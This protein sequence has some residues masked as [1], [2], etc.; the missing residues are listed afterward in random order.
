MLACEYCHGSGQRW[1]AATHRENR[2]SHCRGTGEISTL[3]RTRRQRQQE[4]LSGC[5]QR[6]QVAVAKRL[7]MSRIIAK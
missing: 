5:M 4:R 1:N 6:G 2:C 3:S 7:V